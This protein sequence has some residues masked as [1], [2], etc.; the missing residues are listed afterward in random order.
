MN[1]QS[2]SE[3]LGNGFNW[4]VT[5]WPYLVIDAD[6]TVCA[7]GRPDGALWFT[8]DG[9][10]YTTAFDVRVVLQKDADAGV[11]RLTDRDGT[12]TEFVLQTG[13]FLRQISPGG[14]EIE[15]TEREPNN[16]TVKTVERQVTISGNTTVEQLEYSYSRTLGDA[17]LTSV[18]LR[19]K[20]NAGAWQN[21]SRATYTYYGYNSPH[22]SG[23]DLE[24]ATTHEWTGSAWQETGTSYYRYY[25][26]DAS[27]LEA[28]G[29]SS[30]SGSTPG[31]PL[32][33]L[34][35]VLRPASFER[36]KNDPNMTDP[37]TASDLIVSL[38]ADHYFEYDAD[39]RVTMEMVQGGSQTF[40]YDYETSG[41]DDGYNS[42]KTKTTE[43]LPDGNR[44]IVYSNFAGQTMLTVFQTADETQEWLQFARFGEDG[45]AILT[46]EPAAITGYDEDLPDLL[47][48]DAGMG[49]YD[50]LRDDDGLITVSTFDPSSGYVASVS[51]RKGQ[52]GDL[53]K[54][55]EY[56]YTQCPCEGS[57]SSSSS[58]CDS[59]NVWFKSKET[60]YPSDTDQNKTIVTTYDYDFY[61]D[62][63]QVQQKITTLP[64]VPTDQ[65]GS[66]VGATTR[67]YFDEFGYRTWQM[68]ERG[69][70]THVTYDI[71]TG[72]PVRKV[73]D[74][75]TS[76][77]TDEPAGW[78]TPGGGGLNLIT[79]LEHDSRGRVTQVL[80]PSHTVDLGGSAT[81]IRRAT[82]I[83]YLESP[84]DRI[85]R[86]GQGYATGSSPSY[87]Y[88]L[89]NPVSI[90]I[91]DPAGKVQ[92]EIQATRASTSGKLLPSDTFAQTTYTRW[93]TIQYTDCCHEA[94]QRVYHTIPSS[95]EGSEGTNY[96]QT[97]Y[98]YD[99]MKRRNRTVT[100]GGTIS[101]LVF[102][103]RGLT[104][105]SW[106]GTDDEGATAED[107]T[108]GGL[109]PDN[110]MVLITANEY[111][112]GVDGGN[113]NLTERTQY[114][115]AA[116][117]R[118]TT[119]IYDFR[120]RRTVI[121]G[122]I[123]FYQ[124]DA[125][126]NLGR[127]IK[128][129]R[130]DT[131]S[132]GNLV[133]RS[134]TKYDDR[135]RVFRRI[136]YG[137][138]P[139]NGSVGNSLTDNVWYDDAG[140][141]IKSLPAGSQVFAKSV[142]D[143]LGRR[144]K[145]YQ[146]YDLDESSYADASSVTDDTILE[147]AETAYDTSNNVIQTTTRQRYHNA[148]ANQTGELQNPTTTPKARV[149]YIA[150]YPDVLG[151][152]SASANYGTHGGTALSRSSTIPT[153]SDTV[154]VTST[155]YDTAGNRSA[156][157][158]AAGMTTCFGY[159]DAGREVQRVMNCESSSGSSSSEGACDPSDD[160]DVTV[161]TAY[162]ADGNVASITAVNPVTGNQTT[163]YVYGTTLSD[164]DVA[165][166]L[167]KRAEVY[168][169]SVDGSDR[170]TFAY[171]RQ[172]QVKL[173]TDQQGTVHAYDFDKLGRQTQD[174]ITTLGSGVD[175]AVRRIASAYEVRG[176]REKL[177]SYDNAAVGSGSV[178]N[179]AQFAYNDFD[180]LITDYQAHGGSV[181]T[182]TSPKVQYGY[183]NGSANTVRPTSLT[184]PDGRVLTSGYGTSDGIDDAVSRVASLVDDDATHLADY[185]YLGQSTFIEQDDT[186]P[187]V[188]WTLVDLSG[189]NDLDTGDIYSG[190]DRFGRIKDNRWYDYG[191]SAD[192]DR[193][194][195]GYD[196]AGN[197][198]WRENTV[199][200]ALSKDFDELY[201]ND[202][203]H[204]LKDMQR[205]RL[206][207]GHTALTAKTFAQCW[208]L[209]A[210][211]NWKKFLEDAD[212][213]G[214]W[215]L[216]QER[217]A[218]PVNEIT[219][220]TESAGP[221]WATP[222]Y[223]R[224]GNMTTVPKPSDPTGSYTATYDAWNRLVKLVE[225]VNIVSEY[226]YDGAKR[227]IVQT[228]YTGGSLTETRHLYY[229]KPS[230]WQVIEERVGT[231]SNAER[232]F[233]WGL[234]Y[235][236]DL[237]LRDRTVTD[238]LDERLYGL[239]DANWNVDAITNTT[240]A[241]QQ[242]FAYSAYGQPTFL[243]A[244]FS[245]STNTKGWD[246]LYAGYRWEP[247][248]QLF[249]V[250]NRIYNPMIG[251][252]V[253]RDPLGLRWGT[254]LYSYCSLMPV[255]HVDPLGLKILLPPTLPP[256][257][258]VTLPV[259]VPVI[260]PVVSP[261]VVPPPV[262]PPIP[263]VVIVGIVVILVIGGILL[264]C[265]A[266][267][268]CF[269][270]KPNCDDNDEEEE[271]NCDCQCIESQ[272]NHSL[273]PISVGTMTKDACHALSTER[274]IPDEPLY[275]IDC[276]CGDWWRL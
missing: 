194:K 224:A 138:N 166:S 95:G 212:G 199:A 130:Y 209:D 152:Q 74:V 19:R 129:E 90:N 30:S 23:E 132:G 183:A 191:G 53:I 276:A 92:Q 49:K 82:W 267:G 11:Y 218:N 59:G 6:G 148:P 16:F 117:T 83:N 246:N 37:L 135:G 203:I 184:Y 186:Q 104:A 98:G 168:P 178:V 64:A 231:S 192:V 25:K 7:Q 256:T 99:V 126:D 180:Q 225:G 106:T 214:T 67:D 173:L 68:D 274:Y 260:P 150:N 58:S 157:T 159:D 112:G 193:I 33:L 121:D 195:Y 255:R 70:I 75:D 144:T 206:N 272:G 15:C 63:C 265:Y 227:R 253:Q 181:N 94:S 252:W 201:T 190:F 88:T 48:F 65:N 77:S 47:G 39:R 167:L 163:E 61:P 158:D 176:M 41:N 264:Y 220:I 71:P 27:S 122:E 216:E 207:G 62:T 36:L 38:Y 114:V 131:T 222:A 128:T 262:I 118:V 89:V 200:T 234:R 109:D 9:D 198:I 155:D 57:S 34:K 73:D 258:P 247:T 28:L 229:V 84:A 244:S 230:K 142:Y 13:A 22:G 119:M 42:W 5:Q 171:N 79:D 3:T 268:A 134:E 217:T 187:E 261:P 40:L 237:V 8:P 55:R 107:P 111:D 86:I 179:E 232:Q 269:T 87:T 50:Y 172:G 69:F 215:N 102:D 91:A 185:Q 213:N 241:V 189:T 177:T 235:V 251:T 188:K 97:T 239:Q 139:S 248:S 143:S 115:A 96:D 156:V 113:G 236:D 243:T 170:I 154:L 146:G 93:K 105:S 162:N 110:N 101:R 210:T 259:P 245:S 257:L 116:D 12:V 123:D 136:K 182:S 145:Q 141:Q 2:V 20:V 249:H 108:G 32:Y 1:R 54:L 18:T 29:S 133:A 149:T 72:A 124:K 161:Q 208:S 250:R 153:R 60:V 14:V 240:G 81:T 273:P 221:S 137:V 4:Q 103:P 226:A 125:Y 164:S 51:V 151:R 140:N 46:A 45:R 43:T 80:G 197:R 204:R 275:K 263:P 205:G 175:G 31:V 56:E 254:N 10:D 233:V 35:Y 271:E 242:R 76:L 165:S 21:V 238:P 219:D 147:Q 266:S 78:T 211:G 100:P 196:R 174:R 127:V 52:E 85:T 228:S 160:I 26:G 202:L 169:D 223:N 44:K 66:N 270:E 17:L 24:T 120:N